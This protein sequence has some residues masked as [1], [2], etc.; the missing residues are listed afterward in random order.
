MGNNPSPSTFPGSSSGTDV[1]IGEGDYRISVD[2]PSVDSPPEF[3]THIT[4]S[5]IWSGASS[6]GTIVGGSEVDCTIF[7]IRDPG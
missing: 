1:S 5:G 3:H 7:A 4:C 2:S 6:S